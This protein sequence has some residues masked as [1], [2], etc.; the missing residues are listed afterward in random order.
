MNAWMLCQM[1]WKVSFK[2]LEK[3]VHGCKCVNKRVVIQVYWCYILSQ[4]CLFA[5]HDHSLSKNVKKVSLQQFLE[6]V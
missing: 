2:V 6:F 4:K 5:T 3:T 1:Y